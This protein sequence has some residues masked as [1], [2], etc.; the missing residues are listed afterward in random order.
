MTRGAYASEA[1]MTVKT[2]LGAPQT[3]STLALRYLLLGSFAVTAA[4]CEATRFSDDDNLDMRMSAPV[5]GGFS[6]CATASYDA[7]Q[8]PAA[9]LV[10]LDRSSSMSDNNK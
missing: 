4:A 8:A 5:E 7:K 1:V 10:V 2:R 6:S 9:L 3:R